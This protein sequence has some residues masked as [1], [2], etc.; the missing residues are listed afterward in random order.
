MNS[1][2]VPVLLCSKLRYQSCS[3]YLAATAMANSL[4]LVALLLRWVTNLGLD[5]YNSAHWC[6]FISFINNAC[7]FLS[8]WFVVGFAIDRYISMVWPLHARNM[9]STFRAKTVI[10]GMILIATVVY[11]NMSLTVGVNPV[12]GKEQCFPFAEFRDDLQILNIMDMIV[13]I[14]LPTIAIILLVI[15]ISRTIC[16]QC[17][18]V[19][20]SGQVPL[21][22][23]DT[24][25]DAQLGKLSIIYLIVHLML[26]VPTEIHRAASLLFSLRGEDYIVDKACVVC[27][28]LV[29]LLLIFSLSIHFPVYVAAHKGFT[30]F[31][32][33][34][35]RA[36]FT[37]CH[38]ETKQPMTTSSEED[39]D[40]ALESLSPTTIRV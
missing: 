19:A 26:R 7:T 37:K 17:A 15:L 38:V 27:Q 8:A 1:L 39:H 36:P 12:N 30:Y 13:N 24:S 25:D 16:E 4:C 18:C 9:C 22:S 14:A 6:Q 40:M 3:H 32:S 10:V 11:M 33:R 21:Q 23:D 31:L 29:Q 28:A 35:M 2:S 34:A 5:L 20:G